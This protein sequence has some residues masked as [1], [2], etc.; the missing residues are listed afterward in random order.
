MVRSQFSLLPTTSLGEAESALRVL[1]EWRSYGPDAARRT[2]N[3]ESHQDPLLQELSLRLSHESGPR[4]LID[5]LWFSRPAGGI[6][7]VWDQI[8]RCWQLPELFPDS[9]PLLLIDRESCL[10]RSDHFSSLKVN[11]A[12]PLNFNAIDAVSEENGSIAFNWGA[13]VFLSSW[14]S[15]TGSHYPVCPEL[16]FVHDCMPERSTCSEVL[17]RLRRRW[18]QGAS[19]YLAVSADTAADVSRLLKHPITDIPWCHLAPDPVFADTRLHA[20]VNDLTQR[21]SSRLGLRSPFV[22]LPA[23]SGVG[24]YKNPELVLR[25]LQAP[26]LAAIQLVICGIGSHQRSV[27]FAQYFPALEGRILPLVLSDTELALLYR[28][29]LAV[30]IPSRIEGFGLPVIEV[31]AAGGFPLIADS[32]GLREAGAEAALRFCPDQVGEVVALIRL[33][34]DPCASSWLKGRLAPRQL[35]RLQ[36]L[37]PD[38]LGLSLLVQARRASFG[39]S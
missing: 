16:A 30:I 21:L 20:F 29:A 7:R 25:A 34:L 6:T 3:S 35:F 31:M 19:A 15:T 36:R 4:I 10:A 27:E 38:L 22:V 8:M 5:G 18:L 39:R 33:L 2:L 28:Q 1:R 12:D 23:T 26:P 13:D 24:S 32:R 9:S 17:L 37:H 11:K 14:I